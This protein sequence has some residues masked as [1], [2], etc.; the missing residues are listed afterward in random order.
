[1]L[2]A[3]SKAIFAANHV[4]IES[5]DN[6]ARGEFVFVAFRAKRLPLCWRASYK[7]ILREAA[8]RRIERNSISFE[9][10]HGE[11]GWSFREADFIVRGG[12]NTIIPGLQPF[13]SNER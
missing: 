12:T 6:H 4:Q 8:R 11:M 13:E 1:M 3:E 5:A 9:M 7:K 2:D 10:N